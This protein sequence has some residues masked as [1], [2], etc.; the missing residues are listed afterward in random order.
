VLGF[1]LA[2]SVRVESVI[3]AGQPAVLS[4]N[5]LSLSIVLPQ[6]LKAQQEGSLDIQ[7][8]GD[9]I[10]GASG[11]SPG[12]SRPFWY[13]APDQ[14]D[15]ARFS[16]KFHLPEGFSVLATNDIEA[17]R[18]GFAISKCIM[19]SK[20]SGSLALSACLANDSNADALIE[21]GRLITDF[22]EKTFGS[23]PYKALQ[24]STL[25]AVAVQSEPSL[26]YAPLGPALSR[27]QRAAIGVSEADVLTL[28]FVFAR[29]MARQWFG[30]SVA[31]RT[32]RDRWIVDGLAAYAGAMFIEN[33]AG[34]EA[35]RQ[36]L[37]RARFHLAERSPEAAPYG[38][39]APIVLGP[40]LTQPLSTEGYIFALEN[41]SMWAIH[42]LRMLMR[43][44]G[45]DSRF[46]AM[47]RELNSQYR[48]AFITTDDFKR[49][50]EKHAGEPLD[51]YFTD[52]VFGSG[53]PP[54]QIP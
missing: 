22:Y 39:L 3:A 35:L 48:A 2:P 44:D 28:D 1:V 27:E 9:A 45:D 52:W 23:S 29:E 25:P 46:L 50:A 32:Y 13:P 31:P 36:I 15:R 37:A 41:K 54:E 4:R 30:H 51:S 34:E 24:I 5:G 33:S 19:R 14:E 11:A 12:V 47:L 6:P 26:V 7:F 10:V 53:A 16:I 17:L 42:A 8:A 49:L 20:D 43:R 40:R 38:E 21:H 18:A